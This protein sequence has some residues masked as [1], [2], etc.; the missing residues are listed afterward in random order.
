MNP[1]FLA[2]T[3]GCR[4]GGFAE[5]EYNREGDFREENQDCTCQSEYP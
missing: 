3:T 1:R 5:T 2:Q 4:V